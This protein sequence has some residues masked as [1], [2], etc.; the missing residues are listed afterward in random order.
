MALGRRFA[1]L[2]GEDG[3]MER[4]RERRKKGWI[5][6]GINMCRQRQEG[7]WADGS[8]PISGLGF[9]DSISVLQTGGGNWEE[10]DLVCTLGGKGNQSEQAYHLKCLMFARYFK[11]VSCF[12][13]ELEAHRVK[14]DLPSPGRRVSDILSPRVAEWSDFY[15]IKEPNATEGKPQLCSLRSCSVR[16]LMQMNQQTKHSSK[17]C[18]SPCWKPCISHILF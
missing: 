15:T 5:F 9:M 12:I 13:C 16:F 11:I 10:Q 4:W 14:T 1:L 7:W 3:R 6:G 2:Q 8:F 17:S 18:R